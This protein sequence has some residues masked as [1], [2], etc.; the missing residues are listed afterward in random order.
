MNTH[1]LLLAFFAILALGLASCSSDSPTGN[2]TDTTADY[3]TYL[4]DFGFKVVVE[5]YEDMEHKA[6]DLEELVQDF[7][8]DPSNQSKLDAACT[9][10]REMREAWE[11]S[12]A[13]LFGPA[14][15]LSL[16]PALDSW[17]VDRQQLQGVLDSEFELTPEFIAEGLGAA[18]RGFHTVE[19][20]LFRDGA[21]RNVADITERE[22]EYLVA[23]TQV[24]ADDAIRL[25]EAW[26]DGFAEEFANAGKAGS[27]YGSQTDALIE[28]IEGMSGICDEVANGKIADPF[29]EQDTRLVESQFSWNS[30][31]DFSNNIRGVRNAYTGGYH[32]AEDGKGIDEIVAEK[33]AA[34]DARLKTEIDEA[35]AAINAI[36]APFR[37][38][39]NATVQIE[40]AQAAVLKVFTTIENDVKPLFT[41]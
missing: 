39:L 37:N 9:G 19:Y 25:D 6:M 16:D 20:L 34:L 5:T 40:A 3:S 13:F 15:F 12:E 35:I 17:P 7:A 21:P 30:L 38:N 31:A 33:D 1:R 23:V 36:P 28:I 2:N 32:K 11:S 18:L 41:N 29:D 4:H 14:E 10:W 8:D 24:L 27:R 26:E 22:R